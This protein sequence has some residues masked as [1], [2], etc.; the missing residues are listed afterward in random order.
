MDTISALMTANWRTG[1]ARALARTETRRRSGRVWHT[2]HII[3]MLCAAS[4]C[5]RRIQPPVDRPA[6]RGADGACAAARRAVKRIATYALSAAAS[7]VGGGPGG[8]I[9]FV[10]NPLGPQAELCQSPA[11]SPASPAAAASTQLA[12]V[13]S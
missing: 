3:A 4:R 8:W 9:A 6:H 10:N 13:P 2:F 1:S 5:F 11:S 12:S 7:G